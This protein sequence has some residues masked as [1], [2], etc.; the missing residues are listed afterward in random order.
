MPLG[1]V[2]RIS[3]DPGWRELEVVLSDSSVPGEGEHKI[4]HFI[5][6]QARAPGYDKGQ[7][8]LLYG[9]D[10][11]L[12]MLG[13]S[14]H[15]KSFHILREEFIPP[16]KSVS[17]G[18]SGMSSPRRSVPQRE[19]CAGCVPFVIAEAIGWTTAREWRKEWIRAHRSRLARQCFSSSIWHCCA[20][21]VHCSPYLPFRTSFARPPWEADRQHR[22]SPPAIGAE[23]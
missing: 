1:T 8:H 18:R 19:P 10:A 13:L 16:K 12:I 20:R 4:M 14:T 3:N 11:D 17:S 5:R 23:C 22:V 15:E 2:D 21:W 7:H 6:R 9:A